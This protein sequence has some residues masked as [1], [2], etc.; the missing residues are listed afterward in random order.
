LNNGSKY[1]L[2]TGASSGIG[3]AFA[4]RLAGKK[5]NLILN[6]RRESLLKELAKQLEEQHG[7]K[8]VVVTAD[9]STK[10]GIDAV[11]D[12]LKGRDNLH[13][14]INNAG[15]ANTGIFEEIP[16]IKHQRMLTVHVEAPTRLIHAALPLMLENKAGVIINVCSIAAL[17]KKGGLYSATKNYLL[18]FS[19]L[20]ANR[21]KSQGI[22]VQALCPGLT[23]SGFHQTDEFKGKDVYSAYPKI[24]WMTSEKVV[25]IS[26]KAVKK[27]RVVVITGLRNRLFMKII[28]SGILRFKN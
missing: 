17:M 28:N 26:L 2:I 23:Y 21:L 19:K 16:W 10:E 22:I 9:L 11:V 4:R 1:A 13:F 24:A 6:A 20:L 25:D 7:I 14:L 3:K 15:F 18:G 12:K 8:T 5:Y 27:K